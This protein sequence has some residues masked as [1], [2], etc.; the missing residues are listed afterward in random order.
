MKHLLISIDDSK[1][2]KVHALC[3]GLRTAIRQGKVKPGER[4]PSSRDL[5]QQLN[6]HR[7]TVMT[8]LGE[9]ESEGWIQSFAKRF[10]I[11]NETLPDTF[12]SSENNDKNKIE[13]ITKVKTPKFARPILMT[14]PPTALEYKYSF[15]SGSPDLRLFP[16]KDF[17]SHLYDALKVKN[18]LTYGE[19]EGHPLLIAE[20]ESYLRRVRSISPRKIIVTNGSQEAIF[21]LA[22]SLISPGDKVAVEAL[23]YPPAIEAFKFAGAELLPINIDR[24]GLSIDEL[25]EKLKKHKIKF[26]YVTPLHQYPTTVTLSAS[27]RL[28]LYELAVKNGI[29]IIEDDYDHEFHYRGQPV[30]PMASFDP[31]GIILYVSTFSKVFFPAARVG[32]LSVPEK[33]GEEIARLK[34]I[35]SRQNEHILQATIA[36]WMKSGGFEKHL[37]KMRRVYEERCHSFISDLKIFQETNEK[38][39]WVEPDGGMALWLSLGKN[40]TRLAQNLKAHSILITPESL[41]RLDNKT[42]THIRLGF[43]GFTAQENQVALKYLFNNLRNL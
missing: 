28:R 27:R 26:I 6:I 15:P 34:R 1:K 14:P 20:I 31:A 25:E 29:Y 42:G 35:S 5:A 8:A 41:Y 17:K 38:I 40:T 33:I 22:Q 21:L 43:A 7:Q 36:L 3:D 4:L 10:Y 30:A 37:R 23:S 32:F 13:K 9:L 18:I 19:P 11:V 39:S 2:N 16:M 12:L 24:D